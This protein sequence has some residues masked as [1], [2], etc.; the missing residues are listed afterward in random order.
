M[1]PSSE[2]K[3]YFSCEIARFFTWIIGTFISADFVLFDKLLGKFFEGVDKQNDSI[4]NFQ[5]AYWSYL[6]LNRL[7]F[8]APKALKS[9]FSSQASPRLS[10]IASTNIDSM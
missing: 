5:I 3:K 9:R 10:F 8:I 6:R 2:Q 4:L 1:Q 7:V